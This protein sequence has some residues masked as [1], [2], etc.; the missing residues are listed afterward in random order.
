[1]ATTSSTVGSGLTNALASPARVLFIASK[2]AGK[3]GD[4]RIAFCIPLLIS[5]SV[6]YGEHAVLFAHA[7]MK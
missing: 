2:I 3:S 7:G 5:R 4:P 1:M 6:I